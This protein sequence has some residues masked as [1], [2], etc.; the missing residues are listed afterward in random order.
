MKAFRW[1]AFIIFAILLFGYLT[2][3]CLP[4]NVP[5]GVR[6]GPPL[7]V[8]FLFMPGLPILAAVLRQWDRD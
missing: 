5:D 1:I 2:P 6:K 4:G 8:T 7:W 3:S